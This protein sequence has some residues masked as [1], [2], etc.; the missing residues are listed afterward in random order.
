MET[1]VCT[2]CK[3]EQD[4]SCFWKDKHTRDGLSCWC[5]V[6]AS[7][8]NKKY[9][10]ENKEILAP[11]KTEWRSS[12][13]PEKA[14][15]DAQYVK[16]HREEFNARHRKYAAEQRISNPNFRLGEALRIRLNAAVAK[17]WKSGSA[18]ADLGCS[19][20]EFKT[21]L[22]SKFQPGMTWENWGRGPNCWHIDHV[23]PLSAFDL[24]NR[25][26]LVLACYYMNLQ[27]LWERDNLTK[28]DRY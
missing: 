17:N 20:G 18:V 27:P 19:I 15:Y 16:T 28:G 22:K 4:V 1:K 13:K 23:I 26:H 6:C 11:K 7:E 25:Q 10:S 21:Y 14:A 2:K 8:K 12:R 24:T 3:I 5:K 9:W